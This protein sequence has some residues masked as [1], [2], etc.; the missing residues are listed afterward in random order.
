[1]LRIL[2]DGKTKEDSHNTHV[3]RCL[4]YFATGSTNVL[5][6]VCYSICMSLKHKLHVRF[7]LP[8]TY[9]QLQPVIFSPHGAQLFG[10]DTQFHCERHTEYK[11]DRLNQLVV[12]LISQELST[13]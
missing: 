6:G 13:S 1:M 4:L 10:Q 2:S 11:E 12:E 5:T 9:Q 7:S 3:L 8:L